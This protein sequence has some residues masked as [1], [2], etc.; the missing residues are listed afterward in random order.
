MIQSIYKGVE[1]EMELQQQAHQYWKCDYSLIQH[2][3]RTVTIVHGTEQ[4]AT[5]DLAQE[6]ALQEARKAIDKAG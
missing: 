3:Q 5:M 2:P 1:I 4:F 6:H